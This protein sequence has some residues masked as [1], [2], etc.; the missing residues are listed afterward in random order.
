MQRLID[1]GCGTAQFVPAQPSITSALVTTPLLEEEVL[2]IIDETAPLAPA[3]PYLLA[4]LDLRTE[5]IRLIEILPTSD[6]QKIKCSLRSHLTGPDCPPYIALSYMWDHGP[7]KDIIELNDVEVSISSH[8]WWFLHRMRLRREF[9]PFWID[10]ICIN[11]DS[12]LERNHQVPLM[13]T[14]YSGAASVSIWLGEHVRG[15]YTDMAMRFLAGYRYSDFPWNFRIQKKRL[16]KAIL[17][18]CTCPY[19][20]RI[21]IVQEIVLAQTIT[22]YSGALAVNLDKLGHLLLGFD[23]RDV[24]YAEWFI[25]PCTKILNQKGVSNK[26]RQ[27]MHLVVVFYKQKATV[28]H[29]RIY[30]LCGLAIGGSLITVD[31]SKSLKDV[32]EDVIVSAYQTYIWYEETDSEEEA[33]DGF[34]LKDRKSIEG[35]RDSVMLISRILGV[36]YYVEQLIP[37]L[38]PHTQDSEEASLLESVFSEEAR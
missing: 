10:A 15:T 27:L 7:S 18:L 28:S 21:W 23:Y 31:Y 5:T 34:H 16:Y 13:R 19:W 22:M 3:D 4:P 6:P 14:I 17:A 32:F 30:A 8:L 35:F 26:Y 36:E 24:G 1:P 20:Y 25:S 11:Q 37:V 38:K 2:P 33:S 29:D 9:G 12:I